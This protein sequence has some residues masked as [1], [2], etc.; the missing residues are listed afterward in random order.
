MSRTPRRAVALMAVGALAVVPLVGLSPTSATAAGAAQPLVCPPGMAAS[1]K[2]VGERAQERKAADPAFR[3][4]LRSLDDESAGAGAVCSPIREPEPFHELAA[5]Q[6]ER[7]VIS[8]GPLG[9]T[10]AGAVRAALAG[11]QAATAAA[12]TVPGAQGT[13]TP[14]GTTP[15]LSDV[16][17]YPSTNGSGLADLAGRVD[18]FAYDDVNKRLFAAPGTGGVWLST[19]LGE[20]WRS[21]GESL[22]YQSV[23]AVTWSPDGNPADGT[24]LVVSGEASAGGNVYTG[25][26]AFY[27]T[28]SGRTW[29]QSAGVPDGLMGFDIE[30]DPT[31]PK[32]VYA[33]TS[34]G[35]FRSADAGRTY[36]NVNLPTG[37]CAGVT[38][39]DN[40]CMNANW[41]TDVEVQEPGGA[42]DVEGG[43]VLAVVGYRAGT[44]PYPGTDTP[45][46]PQNGLYRSDTGAVGSFTYLDD[47]YALEDGV[48]VGFAPQRRVGRT[49]LGSARGPEQDHGYLYAIVQDAVLF[50]GGLNAVEAFDPTV[51]T[52]PVPNNTA[53]NGIFV[54]PDFGLSWMRMADE[55]E[56]QSPL[57]ESALIGTFQATLYAPGIQSWY[58]MWIKPDPTTATDAGVP[59]RLVFG[60]EEVWESRLSGTP[61]DGLT[62]SAEPASF[63]VIGPYFADEACL[64]L[65]L[66]LPVCPTTQTRAGVTT[67]HPD[68]QGGIW[69]PG[70]DGGVTLV[71]GHDGGVNTQTAAAGE[72]LSKEKWG[73]GSQNGFNTLLP[74][75]V[76]PARDGTVWYGLQD[77]GS[78]KI[79]PGG[80]QIMAYGGDGFYVA[81][82]P[83]DSEIAYSEH[84]TADM[85]VTQDGGRSWTSIA[86]P[87]SLPSF[88]NPFVMDRTDPEHLM[89]AGPEVV[90]RT[91]G[92]AGDWVEVFNI[93]EEGQPA[94][95]MSSVELYDGNAY[96]GYCQFCDIVN[97]NG[98]DGQIF[99]S[100]LAT[101]VGGEEEPEK[102]S[103]AG[104]HHA[105]AEGLPDRYITSIKADPTNPRTIYVTLSGYANRQ[106]WPVGSF[107]D[108]NPNVGE[109]HVFKSTD[110]GETFTD[111]SGSLPDVPARWVEYNRGQLLVGTDVGVF[112]SNNTSGQRWAA[113][114]GLP[115]VPVTSL[116]NVPGKPNEVVLSTFGRGVYKYTFS[117]RA[118]ASTPVTGPAAPARPSTG[119]LPATGLGV[120][121]AAVG[122]LA[123]LGGLAVRRRLTP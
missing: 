77:N 73:R 102:G 22:P 53:L 41:V 104:W 91:A 30:V 1:G 72:A 119:R 83:D 5:M 6:A 60:L 109:G 64:A 37:D 118:G 122:V 84:T 48:A 123:L 79:E 94:R 58:N 97:K 8:A 7:N 46:S 39:Y 100:G 43:A 114:E 87:V 78:G 90:Q 25:I 89:T 76:A 63:K 62:Q 50:S 31:D 45:Q 14:L 81:V 3:D 29:R 70:D 66:G 82:D 55:I 10:P 67:T 110:A 86:P 95:Q 108:K 75:H 4:L 33:A 17:E 98:D 9:H 121:A 49:E 36:A 15:L 12:S 113:L 111:I 93:D 2:T 19:D 16:E 116:A 112:L 21:V 101:N 40:I 61:Q 35:L 28:D 32:V 65:S 18:T 107:N 57:T 38:G 47:V 103:S 96:V 52:G 27:S 26:G 68:Q 51:L 59:T 85:R 13:F 88:G 34:Q 54:S 20:S 120:T 24:L 56:L 92:P 44:L 106:W 74:Y 105:A 115:N 23:G 80:R 69:V 42:T 99:Q 11:K 117:A 71:V